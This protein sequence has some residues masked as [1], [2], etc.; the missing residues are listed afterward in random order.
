MKTTKAKKIILPVSMIFLAIIVLFCTAYIS[1]RTYVNQYI[2]DNYHR[3]VAIW[4]ETANTIP[5]GSIVFVGDSHTEYFALDEF[6]PEHQ[7]INRGIYGDTTNGVIKR[8]NESVFN[9][10]P[11]KVFLLIGAND[12]N[13]TN[14]T[15]EMIVENINIII[16]QLQ[17]VIPETKIYIQS[18]YPVNSNGK[19]S[20]RIDIYKLNNKRILEINRLLESFC[21]SEDIIFI[22]MFS[23]L[24][25]DNGQLYENFTIEGLHLNAAGYRFVT[26]V[27]RPYVEE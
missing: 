27:L 7:V 20:N 13:K 16:R 22:D 23:Q 6:F 21:R 24:T 12:I 2:K 3:R 18:L 15:N 14:D 10:N 11:S 5:A 25:D 8:L 1:I 9:L 4:Q 19:N 26:E 17:N